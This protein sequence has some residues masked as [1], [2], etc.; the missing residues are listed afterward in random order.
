M[1]VASRA[2]R[3][4]A[5]RVR[6]SSAPNR[7]RPSCAHGSLLAAGPKLAHD[8]RVPP[9]LQPLSPRLLSQ[10][11]TLTVPE[12]SRDGGRDLTVVSDGQTFQCSAAN[13]DTW[14]ITVP[15]KSNSRYIISQP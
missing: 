7:T 15:R 1:T 10:S 5:N 4:V 6:A 14:T 3:A 9:R 8:L 2:T 11:F 12:L 13:G